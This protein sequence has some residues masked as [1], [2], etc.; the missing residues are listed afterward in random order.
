MWSASYP[1]RLIGYNTCL[2]AAVA[3]QLARDPQ[4]PDLALG[5][6]AGVAAMRKLQQEGYG[7]AGGD[8]GVPPEPR[9]PL[10]AVAAEALGKG[11]KLQVAPVPNPAAGG[12]RTAMWTVLGDLRPGGGGP[13]NAVEQSELGRLAREIVQQGPER[14]LAGVPLGVFGKL[15]TADRREIEGYC[16]VRSLISE[17]CQAA[18][19]GPLSLAVFGPPGAGKSFGVNQIA[20][21]LT[22]V[23]IKALTFNLSQF[24]DP[25]QL[26]EAFHQVRD[27]TLAGEIPLVF[28]DEFDASVGAEKL[29]WLRYFLSPMQDGTFQDMQIT[30]HLGRAVFVFAG[31]T[32]PSLQ[33]FDRGGE[34]EAFVAA[35]G[36]DF[37]SR[38][39]GFV[40][41]LGPNQL[42]DAATLG[43]PLFLVRRAILLRGLLEREVPQIF[44]KDTPNLDPGVL[45]AFLHVGRYK[46]GARSMQALIAMSALAGKD[47]Y[48]RSCLP[49]EAQLN[50]HVNGREFLARVQQPELTGEVL[51]RLAQA[52]HAVYCQSLAGKPG[53]PA[54]AEKQFAGL[55]P[56]EQR[57]NRDFVLD[58]AALLWGAGYVM[59]PRR[60]GQSPVAFPAPEVESMSQELHLCWLRGR[61]AAGFRYGPV[62]DEE[63]KLHPAMLW[64]EALS[65]EIAAKLDP[66]LLAVLGPLALPEDEKAKDRDMIRGITEVL[67]RVGYTVARL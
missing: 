28:W 64:W 55:P 3:W 46:H 33:H 27:V 7:P 21:T 23:K 47:R 52:V 16:T 9:F 6:Q 8:D 50:L 13:A 51:E 54:A 38:L 5:L 15:T 32:S 49:P 59:I 57:Q 62:R 44:D 18:Q 11:A 24:N 37:V 67:A 66:G 42:A 4:R 26:V 14:A 60:E 58:V 10:A 1:G 36:P 12:A 22:E 56:D 45:R 41:V 35:K 61:A 29:A 63:G 20:S 48:E 34:D 40:N 17:Y 43:D 25:A 39:K 2:T 53:A 65:D 19:P 31:G 30:Y